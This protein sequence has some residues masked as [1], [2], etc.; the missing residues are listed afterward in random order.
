MIGI[1]PQLRLCGTRPLP[2]EKLAGR[3]KSANCHF[4]AGLFHL[5]GTVDLRHKTN[6]SEPPSSVSFMVAL[7]NL[8]SARIAFNLAFSFFYGVSLRNSEGFPL[9]KATL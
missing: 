3:S 7:S 4:L 5:K 8:A 9:C 6:L 1:V 2:T